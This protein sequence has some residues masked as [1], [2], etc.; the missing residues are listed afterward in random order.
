MHQ[1]NIEKLA[2]G[3]ILYFPSKNIEKKINLFLNKNIK[4]YVF[5]NSK[6]ILEINNQHLHLLG[7]NTNQGLGVALR[8][9][10]ERAFFDKKEFLLYFDQDTEISSSIIK[11]LDFYIEYLKLDEKCISINIKENK[12][13]IFK[14][15]PIT[16]NSGSL[17]HIPKLKKIGF[18]K[19]EIFVDGLDFEF[20]LRSRI[21]GFRLFKAYSFQT[22]N[23]NVNQ[24]G[25]G[26]K[27]F[28][29]SHVLFKKYPNKRYINIIIISVKLFIKS[30]KNNDFAF[31]L[32]IIKFLIIFINFQLI[33]SFI[34]FFKK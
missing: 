28:G 30:L 9:I 4:V 12:E 15:V 21:H 18:H 31:A 3:F 17:Y 26:T 27:I 34:K 14:E 7:N 29:K 5:E 19:K 10:G 8:E 16:I 6:S 32:E 22:I 13:L 23:H 1:E 11:I 25:D 20:S 24:D 2:V 33:V